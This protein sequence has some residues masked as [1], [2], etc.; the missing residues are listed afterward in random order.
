MHQKFSAEYVY[1]LFLECSGV[2]T[3]SRAIVKDC[4]FF[5]LKGEK[6]NGNQFAHEAI[7]LGAKY[8]IVDDEKIIGSS[9][10]LIL[11]NNVL[12]SLQSIATLHRNKFSCPVLGLTGSNGKTTTKELS[13]AVVSKKYF[14][15][16]TVGN[17]NNH[18]GVP[19]TLL[20]TP[21]DSQ[22][23]IVEMGANHQGEIDALCRIAKP[24]MVV[25]TN[26][27]KAHLE[28]FGGIEGVKKGKSEIYNYAHESQSII[29]I[30]S[31][32]QVLMGLLPH[33]HEKLMYYSNKPF[34]IVSDAASLRFV[35]KQKEII[36]HLYGEYN[37]SN[38]SFAV[39]LGRYLEVSEADIL[40]A[41]ENY[42]PSNNRSQIMKYR[43]NEYILDAYNANPSS[44]RASLESFEKYNKPIKVVVLGDMLELGENSLVEHQ[45]IIDKV[46]EMELSDILFVGNHFYRL[47]KGK[48]NFFL[49]I[50]DARD[51]L[52][53]KNYKNALILLKGSRGIGVER[54]LQD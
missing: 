52:K 15:H 40:T 41:I 29:F 48:S 30:N 32:D 9:L 23:V 53:E 5:A 24:N 11:V 22:F 4:M 44:M 12:Q 36:T 31:D 45:L 51:Y 25:I 37:I 8:A 43:D 17:L 26:I 38:I 3:D 27:G 49:N 35:Y 47:G 7:R 10:K 13:F 1:K 28:G 18:I 14:A 20:R 21:L 16:A 6:F 39:A 54:L 33:N 46:N 34:E 50:S 42:M 2:V 19:L